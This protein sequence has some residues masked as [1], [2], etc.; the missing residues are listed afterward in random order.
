[1]IESLS[2]IPFVGHLNKIT[3]MKRKKH[4]IKK[5][6]GDL[7]KLKIPQ[8]KSAKSMKTKTSFSFVETLFVTSGSVKNNWKTT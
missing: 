7:W 4:G 3:D 1:M 8:K 6:I 2:S 5:E